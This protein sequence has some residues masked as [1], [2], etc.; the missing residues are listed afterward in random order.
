MS[1]LKTLAAATISAAMMATANAA[2]VAQTET[3]KVEVTESQIDEI[4]GVIY[5]QIHSRRANRAL[6]MTLLVPRTAEKKPAIVYFPGGGFT[7]SDYEKFIE[8]RFA[9]AKAGFVV[10]A[11]EYRTVPNVFPAILEDGKSAIRFLRANA[12]V[13]GID[14]SKIGVLGD[15]AGGSAKMGRDSAIQAIL[16]LWGKM[17]NVEKARI[18]KVY[19]NDKLTPV[20]TAL[21]C[22]IGDEFDLSKLRYHKVFIMADA[23]VDGS[24]I[25]TLLLTFF[26]RFMRPLIENGHVY[27]AQPPLYKLS[28]GKQEWYFYDDDALN[29]FYE[30]NGRKGYD[31]QRYKGL[32]EMNPEQLWETTMDPKSRTLLRVT[33]EDAISADEMFSVLMGEQPEL[34]RAFIEENAKLVEDLDV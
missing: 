4:G 13:F 31:L 26:F 14:A 21:G 24:H 28:R 8:M 16:P 15:S 18:D 32:G 2:P 9:L 19:G 6:R 12:E 5:S 7:S 34:R 10:A 3:L 33:M 29:A 30:E 27:I 25:C 1:A 11:A 17:L 22:G 23:D 20:V